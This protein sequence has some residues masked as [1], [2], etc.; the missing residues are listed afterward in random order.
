MKSH[1]ANGRTVLEYHA[2]ERDRI[3]PANS[4]LRPASVLWMVSST[5]ST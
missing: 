5:Y 3:V 1:S 4:G 2:G